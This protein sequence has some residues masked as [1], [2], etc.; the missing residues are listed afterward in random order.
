MRER[1]RLFTL[2]KSVSHLLS[3]H[4]FFNVYLF[5]EVKKKIP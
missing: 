2:L 5:L 4:Y 1:V 3:Y